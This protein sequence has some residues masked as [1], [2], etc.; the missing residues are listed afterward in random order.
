LS[1]SREIMNLKPGDHVTARDAA[2]SSIGDVL[3]LTEPRT[4]DPLQGVTVPRTSQINPD[5]NRPSHLQMIHAQL[6]AQLPIPDNSGHTLHLLPQL[7]TN[8]EY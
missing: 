8:Q 5:E 1:H 7:K 3:R 2:A 6:V 4:D